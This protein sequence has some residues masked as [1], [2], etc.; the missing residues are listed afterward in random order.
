MGLLNAL[1]SAFVDDENIKEVLQAADERAK[2]AH[3]LAVAGDVISS[4]ASKQLKEAADGIAAVKSKISTVKDVRDKM[5]AFFR[6]KDAVEVLEG[7]PHKGVSDE[8]AA[9]AFDEMF[10]AAAVFAESLP[11]PIDQYAKILKQVKVASFFQN[12]QRLGASRVGGNAST[13]TGR[14][15]QKVNEILERQSRGEY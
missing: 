6:L 4:S 10:G 2:Q 1:R 9:A 12:M 3:K 7:W 13:P 14:Q 8:A 15:M 11:P 5:D